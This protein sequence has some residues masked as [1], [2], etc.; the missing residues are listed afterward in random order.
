MIKVKVLGTPL[1]LDFETFPGNTKIILQNI[2]KAE[3]LTSTWYYLDIK[4]S[5]I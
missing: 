3:S 5:K 2:H 4:P 1:E